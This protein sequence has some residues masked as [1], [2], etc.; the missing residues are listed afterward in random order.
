MGQTCYLNVILQTLFH[1]PLL[2]MYFLGNGH[3]HFE[4][5]ISDCI[6]CAMVEAFADFNSGEKSEG[7][8]ALSLLLKSW[9]ASLVRARCA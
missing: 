9:K 5:Q 7:F 6:G 3:Q 8:A 4:C 2:N 1:D